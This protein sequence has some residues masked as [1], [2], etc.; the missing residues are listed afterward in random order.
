MAFSKSVDFAESSSKSGC[1]LNTGE[2][3]NSSV[4]VLKDLDN[5]SISGNLFLK[6]KRGYEWRGQR[7]VPSFSLRMITM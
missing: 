3:F 1:N 5:P 4:K 6:S 7:E 2:I